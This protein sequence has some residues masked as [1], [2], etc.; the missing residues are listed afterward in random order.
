M[1]DHNI[2]IGPVTRERLITE[3][4]D[5]IMAADIKDSAEAKVAALRREIENAIDLALAHQ[6]EAIVEDKIEGLESDLEDA[7]QVAYNR[8][9]VEWARSNYPTWI[10][11]L[12]A[13]RK[14]A[15]ARGQ[16]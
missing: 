3:A 8:G 15:E 13:N 7:V 14:A 6:K 11:R 2:G 1:E 10:D 9:A 4:L 12:E 16:C 5:A